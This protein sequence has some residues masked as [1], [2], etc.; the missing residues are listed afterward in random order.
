MEVKYPS[1]IKDSFRD[2]DSL[3][4]DLGLDLFEIY[5]KSNGKESH[6]ES[7]HT[8]ENQSIGKEFR[9]QLDEKQKLPFC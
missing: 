9:T 2:A 6:Q 5:L 3:C 1:G 7:Q 4:F 8:S